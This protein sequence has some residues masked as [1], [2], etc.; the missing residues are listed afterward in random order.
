MT[1]LRAAVVVVLALILGGAGVAWANNPTVVATITNDFNFADPS[2]GL[3]PG[4][5]GTVTVEQLSDGVLY[6]Q[7]QLAPGVSFNVNDN[8]VHAAFAFDLDGTGISDVKISDLTSG[9]TSE[10]SKDPHQPPFGTDFDYTINYTGGAKQGG[11]G[12][13][14]DFEVS[15]SGNNLILADLKP[16]GSYDGH[17]IWFSSDV[18]SNGHT[19][20]VGAVPEPAMW[21]LMLIGFGLTGS[22]MRYARRKRHILAA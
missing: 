20:N 7:I 10:G 15:D 12:S 5:Y 19:G 6:F 3:G 11:G 2:A 4:P 13:T 18:F 8:K 16:G 17:G 1:R 22:A 9:F 14:L 21:A